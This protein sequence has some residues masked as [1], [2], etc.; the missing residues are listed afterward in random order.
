MAPLV[1]WTTAN[2]GRCHRLCGHIIIMGGPV[3]RG[4]PESGQ[5]FRGGVLRQV[6]EVT[7]ETHTDLLL[8]NIFLLH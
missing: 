7:Q 4:S 1:L 2:G 3:E 6:K 5:L 8:F